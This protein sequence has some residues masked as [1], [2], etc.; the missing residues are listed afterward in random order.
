MTAGV[1]EV[2]WLE[3]GAL[4][5]TSNDYGCGGGGGSDRGEA[6]GLGFVMIQL[7]CIALNSHLRDHQFESQRIEYNSYNK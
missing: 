4:F 3:Q 2:G 6:V 5:D 7:F 1:H